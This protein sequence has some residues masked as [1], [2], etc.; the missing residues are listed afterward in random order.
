MKILVDARTLGSRPSGIGMY[1]FDFIK[2]LAEKPKFNIVLVT[3]V[4]ESEHI[5]H[6]QTMGIPV[7]CYGK[8]IFRSAGVFSYFNFIGQL[9]QK[10]K[11]DIFWEPNNLI[12]V[13][14]RNFRGV[15]VLTLH[16]L[17]PITEPENFSWIY[18]LYYNYSIRKSLKNTDAILYNSAQT[19]QQTE[20]HFPVTRS[21]RNLISYLIVSKAP[22]RSITDKGY[23]LYIGNLEK[24][25]G[26]DLLL[27]A[28]EKYFQTNGDLPLYLAGSIRES[29]IKELLDS[30]KAKTDNIHYLGYISEEQKF[31]LLANCSCFVF[32]SR[33]EGFGI[34]PLE[35]L[36]YYKPIITSD[37]PIFKEIISIPHD[38]FALNETREIAIQNLTTLLL[39]KDFK[40]PK[41]DECNQML[42]S[43]D[44]TILGERL[45]NFLLSLTED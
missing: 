4:A 3:D 40:Q 33:A 27:E 12:P 39:S 35:A 44:S 7:I 34:P 22:S 13:K 24:R 15:T 11:P 38:T 26:T 10:E 32:P 41:P 14:F 5:H 20:R 42:H 23:F 31:D 17:F 29:D 8:R 25:K 43:Y 16:D 36:A 2:A 6:L 18:R 1:L 45:A 37:L 28:Y 9:L 30:L 19:K 21:K